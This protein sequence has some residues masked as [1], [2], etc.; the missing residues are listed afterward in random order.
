M[1]NT[2]SISVAPQI[3]ALAAQIVVVDTVVDAI[4]AV[5]VPALAAEHVV[6]DNEIAVID[7]VVDDI[8][9]TDLP[10]VDAL[11]TANGVILADIHDTDLPAVI[12]AIANKKVMS[13]LKRYQGS[14]SSTTYVTAIDIT[15]SGMLYWV[16]VNKDAST[17]IHTNITID[18]VVYYVMTGNTGDL[19]LMPQLSPDQ[20]ADN[21]WIYHF[22]ESVTV[23]GAM[24]INWQ[25]QTGLKIEYKAGNANNV[26][27]RFM[28]G[29][30]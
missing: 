8:R 2:G 1:A 14:T 30:V 24:L 28:F 17:Q 23:T 4:R 3:A 12:T 13:Q 10:A 15:G 26:D 18:G 22:V 6:I 16:Q 5:D 29:E 20:D 19:W 25:F 11:V 27:I 21:S 7:A 9:D